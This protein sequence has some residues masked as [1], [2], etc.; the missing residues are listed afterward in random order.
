MSFYATIQ[1]GIKYED[2]AAFRNAVKILTEGKWVNGDGNF[3]DECGCVVEDGTDE[4]NINTEKKTIDIPL[5]HAR[6]LAYALN[7]LFI[8]ATG[9]IVYTS[10]DGCEIGGTIQDGA[11]S[12]VDLKKWA[13]E[14]G[15]FEEK[16]IPN[17][18]NFDEYVEFL[19]EVEQEFHQTY[20]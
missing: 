7:K 1:G 13:V 8:G 19:N 17:E 14:S 20:Y 12:E 11:S 18:D 5:H 9:L 4:P 16:D 15:G 6:N 10:T 3:Q 2:E